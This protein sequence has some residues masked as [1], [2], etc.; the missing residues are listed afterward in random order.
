MSADFSKRF[1]CLLAGAGDGRY[2]ADQELER[3]TSAYRVPSQKQ[4]IM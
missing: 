1:A 3:Q 2:D 4:I